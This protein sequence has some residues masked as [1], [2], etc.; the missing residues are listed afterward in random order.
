M[1]S[2]L[3]NFSSPNQPG[4]S[5]F[6]K[7]HTPQPGSSARNDNNKRPLSSPEF[8]TPPAKKMNPNEQ[9]RPEHL[10]PD[11]KLLYDCLSHQWDQRINPLET[12]VNALF[13]DDSELPQHVEDVKK[14]TKSQQ[15]IKTRLTLVEKENVELKE[16]LT[17]I[18]DQMLETCVLMSGIRED[19]W[20]EPGPRRDLVDKELAPLLPGNTPEEKLNNAQAISIVKTE[21]VG[22][23]NPLKNRPIS[24]KFAVKKDADWLLTC[25]QKLNKGIYVDKQYSEET[26]YQRKRLRPI[27]SAA[28]RLSEF[29]GKCTMEGT[30]VKIRGKK[31]NWDNLTRTSTEPESTRSIKSTKCHLLR[32][33]WRDEPPFQFPSSPLYP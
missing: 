12:K 11:L 31:Y 4:I 7:G 20:E 14:I 25:K 10:P 22:R 32:L 23:Y 3:K 1:A 9:L 30:Y 8:S 15:K 19:K 21:R 29:R 17:E 24:I 18:E 13:R 26:E 27:L 16:K 6:L 2:K 28:R 33:L 5:D